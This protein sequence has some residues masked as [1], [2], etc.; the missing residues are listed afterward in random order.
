MKHTDATE[1]LKRTGGLEVPPQPFI[2]LPEPLDFLEELLVD[3]AASLEEQ[4]SDKVLLA[5][6]ELDDLG[7]HL[8]RVFADVVAAGRK[9]LTT[10]ESLYRLS[11]SASLSLSAQ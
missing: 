10:F 4:L 5:D 11:L 7:E 6:E 3:A 9:K 2:F 1:E 8:V